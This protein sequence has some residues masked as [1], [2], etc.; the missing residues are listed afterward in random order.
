[1]TD[2]G[3]L[4]EMVS[5]EKNCNYERHYVLNLLDHGPHF[6]EEI[7]K[8]V[9]A[10]IND[11]SK[12]ARSTTVAGRS[13]FDARMR[14]IMSTLCNAGMA[15]SIGGRRFRIT[16]DGR[17][18]YKKPENYISTEDLK[19]E[20][21]DYHR[22][23]SVP[24]LVENAPPSENAPILCKTGIVALIDMLG[25]RR[26]RSPDDEERIHN[27]W[28]AFKQYA[29]RLVEEDP[30]LQ[31]CKVSAFSDTMFVTAKGNAE[32]L[33]GAFG[34]VA[35]S[36]IPK[37]IDLDIPIRGC[38]AAGK[39]YESGQSLFTGPAVSEAASYYERP[40]WIGISS[41]PSAYSRIDGM[42]SG[43]ACYT[44]YDMPLKRSV[45][46]GA[47]VANWPDRY[48]YEHADREEE[49]DRMLV[50]LDRRMAQ[51]ADIDAS[52]KWRNTRDF[53]CAETGTEGRPISSSS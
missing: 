43:R 13:Q 53:L 47:L 39:F 3:K 25:T 52:L 12:E 42:G 27:N 32:P 24:D 30:G 7:E 41:C 37:S 40:Q 1:M 28:S 8:M 48:N 10:S 49:L 36:L 21:P 5:D 23:V 18:M 29:D 16:E 2:T 50:T 20:S 46:Y 11:Y 14:K 15:E 26:P 44:K 19:K 31:D 22:L 6:L 45:E 9:L 38:V 51:A 17:K 35:A 4:I 33:L 34:R